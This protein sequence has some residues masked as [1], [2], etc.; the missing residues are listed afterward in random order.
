V[1]DEL[2][3]HPDH[4]LQGVIGIVVAVGSGNTRTAV[5][6]AFPLLPDLDPV[7]FDHRVRQ[8]ASAR[9]VEA[10]T[11]FLDPISFRV[12]SMNFPTR[13]SSTPSIPR[14]ESDARIAFPAGRGP[15]ALA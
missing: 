8:E 1:P 3:V 2:R 9:L 13:T 7:L 12:I 4:V 15:P 6:I 14:W 10:A 5:F 11:R